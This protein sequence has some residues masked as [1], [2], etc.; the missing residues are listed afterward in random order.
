[1][2]C[3]KPVVAPDVGSIAD[4]VAHG[5]TGFLYPRGDQHALEERIAALLAD[6]EMAAT[7]GAAGR[8]F[9]AEHASLER[10]VDGYERLI[11]EIYQLKYPTTQHAVPAAEDEYDRNDAA[12]EPSAEVH[13][14]HS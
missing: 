10:M 12:D 8:R 3:G 7:F 14:G 13:A 1:M 4:S 6:G 2:A 11:D 5:E 9:V